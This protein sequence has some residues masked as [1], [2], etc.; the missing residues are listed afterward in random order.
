MSTKS[1]VMEQRPVLPLLLSMAVPPIISM[2][3]QALYNVVDSY[4]VAKI[5]ESAFI[6]V[7]L[8]YPLQNLVLAIGVGFGIGL[9]SF[10][11]RCRGAGNRE[12]MEQAINHAVVLCALHG[13]AFIVAGLTLIGPFFRM[14]TQD[15]EVL[16]MGLTYGT[17]VIT[18]SF[19]NIYHT[20]VEKV[21]QS[22]GNMIIPMLVQGTGAILNIILDPILIFG[23]YGFPRLGV[24]GAAIATVLGNCV[25]CGSAI[26]LFLRK[27]GDLHIRLKGFR[28]RGNVV[29][30]IYAVALPSA[31]M[32]ALPSALVSVLNAIAGALSDVGVAVL[33]VYFKLQSFVYMP[34]S[35]VIQGMR[36]IVGYHFGAKLY[37]RMNRVIKCAF[38]VI[39]CMMAC[40]TVLFLCAS[41][42]IV[43]RF[44]EN[45]LTV[46]QGAVAL[47]IIS[48]GFVFSAAGVLFSGV[49]EAMG[50]GLYSLWI[51]LSRQLIIIPP[52]AFVLSRFMGITG[53]WIA[54]P[55]AEC[56]T[57]LFAVI[58]FL[59]FRQSIRE[60]V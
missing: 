24:A 17:I 9:N 56:V 1:D 34:A 13:L 38:A 46:E 36:P 27:K 53:V 30:S 58:L 33:G 25:A 43:A 7:S 51:S 12:G 39:A 8:A 3:I 11:S 48:L 16:G 5:S 22:M 47:K 52:L 15:P 45:P 4:F 59:W 57:A 44:S 21:F 54:F 49:F 26:F 31:A 19:V 35:G 60:T 29:K 42:P 37:D 32:M 6:S 2:L 14:F 28:F 40:G 10:I 50:K 23:L 18:F 55:I 41:G 20:A